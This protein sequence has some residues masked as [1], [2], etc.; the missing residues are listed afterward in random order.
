MCTTVSDDPQVLAAG[1]VAL[2]TIDGQRRFLAVHR[3]RYDDWSLPK[4]KLD[5]GETF[6]DAALRE[7]EEET[8]VRAR[9]RRPLDPTTYA[10]R[11]GRT[12][13]VRWWTVEVSRIDD[14]EPDDE[15]DEVRWVPVDAAE[16]VLSYPSDVALVAKAAT[17]ERG[18][19]VLVVRHTRAG[20]RRSWDTDDRR[21]PVSKK[22]L[23]QAHALVQQLDPYV[24]TRVL[25]SPYDRCV[26]SIEPLADV[27]GVAVEIED[28]LA[29]GTPLDATLELLRE[30][31]TGTVLCSHGD[32]I[33]DL[34][35]HYAADLEGEDAVWKKGST[36]VLTVDEQLRLLG[37]RY[38]S[39][40]R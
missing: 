17:D 8:G 22:G 27:R 7:L 14:R 10:D 25:S 13:L 40:P 23:R 9:L 31:G 28:R 33:G 6:E 30:L 34:I 4:G 21:R 36:W 11:D 19:T 32:V 3:P 39:P 12:K 37:A 29:E 38:L 15:V 16:E 24:V 2:H 35:S 1:A 18:A 26:Q 5:P 20:E